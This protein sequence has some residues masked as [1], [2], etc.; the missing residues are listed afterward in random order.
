M[1]NKSFNAM[2]A[3]IIGILAASYVYAV[4][5]IFPVINANKD[6]RPYC[7]EISI[8]IGT[9]QVYSYRFWDEEIVF[10]LNRFITKIDAEKFR[11]LM[12]QR[13]QRI[14]VLVR[15]KNLEELQ[16]ETSGI[17]FVYNK[18]MSAWRKIY[19]MSNRPS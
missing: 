3:S 17:P 12:N 19:L 2:F 15:E 4:V 5:A 13:E 11:K 16:I 10:Y 7:K 8:L 6:M 18:K 9:D 14:F 1:R